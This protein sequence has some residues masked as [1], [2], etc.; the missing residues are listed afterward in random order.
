MA[1]RAKP[2]NTTRKTTARA[3]K[4]A[5]IDLDAKEV[6]SAKSATKTEAAES[7][8]K[9]TASAQ[10]TAS[11]K[12]PSSKFGRPEKP[13]EKSDTSKSSSPKPDRKPE[14]AESVPGP[15]S[16]NSITGKLASGAIGGIAALLGFGAIGLWDGA[17]ELPLIGNFYNSG[18]ASNSASPQIAALV[19]R[20]NSLENQAAES[21]TPDLTEVNEK[22]AKIESILSDFPDANQTDQ[23]FEALEFAV[24]DLNETL[25]QI[26]ETASEEGTASSTALSA[27]ITN[28]TSRLDNLETRLDQIPSEPTDASAILKPLQSRLDQLQENMTG[29]SEQIA[30]LENSTKENSTQLK[31]LN[32]QSSNL[33][34]SI[35]SVKTSEKVARS[36]AVNALATALENDDPLSLPI[37]SV[38]ALVGENPN[39]DTLAALSAEG[40]PTRKNLLTALQEFTSSLQNPEN[41]P[42]DQSITDR[43]WANAQSLVSFRSTG[44]REGND[45]FAI[46][47]RVKAAVEAGNLLNAKNE[48]SE[49][50]A[51]TQKKGEEWS[52][53]LDKR[54]K[55]FSVLKQLTDQ[56]A[57][58][59]G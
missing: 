14:A 55:A 6:S 3:K 33:Q 10:A 28:A 29:A 43:F 51:E 30:K 7:V 26:S 4:P 13:D 49:L 38:R 39:T 15:N 47:S 34:E 2:R 9:P 12:S 53:D 18:S 8:T 17:R 1:S 41:V 16:S 21:S 27:A 45:T 31:A 59:A 25:S 24:A 48:W 42:A 56:L 19:D 44:P 40:I 58:N 22:F 35:A 5:T 52:R 57:A 46:L 20:I 37:S 50:P 32:S 23:R 36:V 54:I 11:S